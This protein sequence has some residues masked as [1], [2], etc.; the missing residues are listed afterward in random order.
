VRLCNLWS[1]SRYG[2]SMVVP[3]EGEGIAQNPNRRQKVFE[4]TAKE[5]VVGKRTRARAS[6]KADVLAPKEK[7]WKDVMMLRTGS[8]AHILDPF[9]VPLWASL[10]LKMHPEFSIFLSVHRPSK[11]LPSRPKYPIHL[12]DSPHPLHP[13]P[14]LALARTVTEA[15]ASQL[16]D[17]RRPPPGLL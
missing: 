11:T 3:S 13:M 10:G 17:P 4:I 9:C 16:T 7:T 2:V 5:K 1:S 8:E 6:V 15:T 12:A 14:D